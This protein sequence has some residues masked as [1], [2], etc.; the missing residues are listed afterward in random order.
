MADLSDVENALVTLIAD[1][2]YPAGAKQASTAG[3]P[4]IVYAGWPTAPSLDAD[5]AS[6]KVHVSVFPAATERNTSRYS[7]DWEQQS[8][9]MATLTL[10]VLGQMVTVGGAMPVPF[11]PHV[12]S[13]TVNGVPH[14]YQVQPTDT[15]ASIAQALADLVGAS[16]T[17]IGVAGAVITMPP[18]ARIDGARVGV[19][20]TVARELRRQQRE[21]RITVWADTPA[22]RIAVSR[23]VDVA[24]AEVDRILLPDG[25]NARLRYHSSLEND[26]QQKTR[27]YRR[28]FIYSVEYATTQ[29][30]AATQVTQAQ[31]NASGRLDGATQDGPITT[32]YF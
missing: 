31:L 24:L 28:D 11:T 9:S 22:R 5:L 16:V 10:D 14:P 15:L 26:S 18:G 2:L 23:V 19:T 4:V 30:D 8:V 3:V 27:L 13:L 29:T 21:F 17:G 7:R 25:Q 6:G 32:T 1:A 12:L 20:G